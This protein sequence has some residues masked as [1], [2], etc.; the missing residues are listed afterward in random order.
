[1]ASQSESSG[2]PILSRWPISTTGQSH[3]HI[4]GTPL[5]YPERSFVEAF[6]ADKD[7]QLTAMRLEPFMFQWAAAQLLRSDAFAATL[8]YS[9]RLPDSCVCL[10]DESIAREPAT[11]LSVKPIG[12]KLLLAKGI[13]KTPDSPCWRPTRPRTQH[14]T[15]TPQSPHPAAAQMQLI[16]DIDILPRENHKAQQPRC[17][18]SPTCTP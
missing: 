17:S 9:Y 5:A 11:A 12:H 15:T 14:A 3:S 16:S 4:N 8:R 10:A 1:M 6:P 2:G 13:V 18:S 7:F